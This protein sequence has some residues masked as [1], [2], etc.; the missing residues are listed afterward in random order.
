MTRREPPRSADVVIG[1]PT[2]T[3]PSAPL[4]RAISRRTGATSAL[5]TLTGVCVSVIARDDTVEC[6][7]LQDNFA[8][9]AAATSDLKALIDILDYIEYDVEHHEPAAAVDVRRA[10]ERLRHRLLSCA[11]GR[12]APAADLLE[13][14]ARPNEW[15]FHLNLLDPTAN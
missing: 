7:S 13:D 2:E 6:S 8:M 5:T 11:R 15:L 9:T 14:P 4:R 3:F 1:A 10:S 12:S